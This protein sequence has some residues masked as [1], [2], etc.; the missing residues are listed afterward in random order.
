VASLVAECCDAGTHTAADQLGFNLLQAAL[1]MSEVG[2][3]R[4]RGCAHVTA[5]QHVDACNTVLLFHCG[6]VCCAALCALPFCTACLHLPLPAVLQLPGLREG[7]DDAMR[8]LSALLSA[9]P[10]TACTAAAAAALQLPGL[11]EGFDDAWGRPFPYQ[12]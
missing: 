11:G 12:P 4:W 3:N 9:L 1:R 5:L 8:C 10:L 6:S 2:E 7:S